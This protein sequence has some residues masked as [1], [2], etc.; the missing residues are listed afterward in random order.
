M[1]HASHV[2]IVLRIAVPRD[3]RV[4]SCVQDSWLKDDHVTLGVRGEPAQSRYEI[5]PIHGLSPAPPDQA[6]IVCVSTTR[7]VFGQVMH[8]IVA[9]I[10]LSLADDE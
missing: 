8:V 7:Q 2:G 1:T 5:V 3:G 4:P 9:Q 10:F 6:A